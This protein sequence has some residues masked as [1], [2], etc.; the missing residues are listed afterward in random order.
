MVSS[1]NLRLRSDSDRHDSRV[2]FDQRLGNIDLL[3]P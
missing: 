3:F 1:V 2:H